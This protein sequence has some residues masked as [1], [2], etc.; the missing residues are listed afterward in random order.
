MDLKTAMGL[1]NNMTNML[2]PQLLVAAADRWQ[3]VDQGQYDATAN[4]LTQAAREIQ[5]L[6]LTVATIA[7]GTQGRDNFQP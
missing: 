4:L 5:R 7:N 2:I 1:Q 6:E 3:K